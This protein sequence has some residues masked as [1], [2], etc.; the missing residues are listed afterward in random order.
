MF[1]RGFKTW[2]ENVA[3]QQRRELKLRLFDPLDPSRLATHLGVLV[4]RA[5]EVPGLDPRYL[6][7]LTVDDSDSWSAVTL[8]Y[9]AKDLIILNPSH[10]GGRPASNLMHELSHILLG[11][12]PS[13]IDISEDG[14]LMLST[15][16]KEQEEEATWLAGTLLLPREALMHARRS[17]MTSQAM[18]KSYGVSSDMLAYRT[19]MTGVDTQLGRARASRR[20]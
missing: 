13:R 6:R 9:G 16:N 10:S 3:G 11:H 1:A 17:G 14:L 15:F 19:R 5:D 18:M 12:E 20:P 2:C 4:W 7:T 8:C